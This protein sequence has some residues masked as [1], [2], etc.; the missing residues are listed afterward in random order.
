MTEIEIAGNGYFTPSVGDTV[1]GLCCTI[2]NTQ[3]DIRRNVNGPTGMAEA[4]SKR[5]HLHDVVTCPVRNEK[6][7]RQAF[8]L[9]EEAEKTVS[10]RIE[11]LLMEEMEEI[12]KTRKHTKEVSHWH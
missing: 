9:R 11:D 6:W 4:M 5:G 2:C 1:D 8:L 3:M 7:H 10:K 12:V